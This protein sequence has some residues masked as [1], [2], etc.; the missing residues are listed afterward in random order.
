MPALKSRGTARITRYEINQRRDTGCLCILSSR[1]DYTIISWIR[2]T[3]G[4]RGDFYGESRR[5]LVNPRNLYIY[6]KT[7]Q[8]D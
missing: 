3:N 4:K 8:G 5:P 1:P 2:Q 7:Y 6:Y